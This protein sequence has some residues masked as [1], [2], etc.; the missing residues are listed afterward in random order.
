MIDYVYPAIITT[1]VLILTLIFLYNSINKR[2][3][4]LIVGPSNSGKTMLFHRMIDN[5]IVNTLTSSQENKAKINNFNLIDLAG[6][7]KLRFRFLDFINSCRGL[8]FCLDA[9]SAV[10]D[11]RPLAEYLYTILTNP[12]VQKREL[13]VLV[14]CNKN[15]LL[16]AA[17]KARIKAAI[18]IEM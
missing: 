2:D 1:L 17:D 9:T 14:L 15:D 8:M 5:E 3:T 12:I 11:T 13:P 4:F 18:E 16:L 7:Q 10:K 6:H